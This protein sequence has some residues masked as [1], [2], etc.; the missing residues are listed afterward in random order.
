MHYILGKKGVNLQTRIKNLIWLQARCI[1]CISGSTNL[2]LHGNSWICTFVIDILPRNFDIM[3]LGSYFSTC[4]L[5]ISRTRVSL[6]DVN[7]TYGSPEFNIYVEF[8]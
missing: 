1:Y 7:I 2:I 5:H 3:D 4:F 8:D 6:Y